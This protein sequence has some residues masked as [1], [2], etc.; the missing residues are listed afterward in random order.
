MVFYWKRMIAAI[1]VANI[2]S[3]IALYLWGDVAGIVVGVIGGL[4]FGTLSQIQW[5]TERK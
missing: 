3:Q 1:V 5:H 4:I 2:F